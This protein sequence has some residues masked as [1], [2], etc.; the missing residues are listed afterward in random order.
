MTAQLVRLRETASTQ[1]ELHHLAEAG[2]PAGTAV[3]AESQASGRGS[4]RH[5]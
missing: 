2:A 3:V 5:N 1:D 4:R